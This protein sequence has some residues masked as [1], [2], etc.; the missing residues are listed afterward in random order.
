[1]SKLEIG[2]IQ[3]TPGSR[4]SVDLPVANLYTHTPLTMPVRVICG[5][6]PGPVMFITAALHG[7]ELNGVEIIRRLLRQPA[8][9]R[10]RGTLLAMPIVNVHGFIDRSRYL[11]DR[12][13]LNR[14]FPGKESGSLAARIAHGI[15]TEVVAKCDYGIDLHTGAIHRSNLPQVR[16][17]LA[18]EQT[19]Q[20]AEAFGA[21]VILDS[22]PA[23]GTLR[24]YTTGNDI[25][26][27]LYEAGEALRFDETCIRVGVRGV[28]N[29]LRALEM[30]PKPSR[31][32]RLR[33]TTIASGSAWARAEAS[34][35]L[36][37]YAA[38]GERIAEGQLLAHV[39]DPF[40]EVETELLAP[41]SGLVIGKL[42]LPLVFEGEAVFHIARARGAQAA[43]AEWEKLQ[44]VDDMPDTVITD[45]PA[46]V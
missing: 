15:V 13:D 39:T 28:L 27:L 33:P 41:F 45:E 16:A 14:S 25:P 10:L 37:T 8:L 21:P 7:D 44:T 19:R 3:A 32:A 6:K 34:G 18:H 30:L 23:A 46:I 12:R 29:V 20:L 26:V 40:G 4:F 42:N 1:M 35:V 11:P 43:A 17:H 22:R 2:G 36:R 9:K 5:K 31:P 38:L 24:E